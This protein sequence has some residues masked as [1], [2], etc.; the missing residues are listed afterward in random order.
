MAFVRSLGPQANSPN[1]VISPDTV[2]LALPNIFF[3]NE[4]LLCVTVAAG[5][6]AVCATPAG[7]G[8]IASGGTN[9]KIYVFGRISDGT[10][11]FVGPQLAW[12][13]LTTGTAGTPWM[14]T[15]YSVA[16][17]QQ[18]LTSI[19]DGVAA[20]SDQ[21][22]SS[23]IQAGGGALTTAVANSVVV[24]VAARPDDDIIG[25]MTPPVAGTDGVPVWN[26]FDSESTVSGAD[27]GYEVYWGTK[28][29]AG[30]VSAKTISLTGLGATARASS[31]LQFALKAG[32]PIY[33]PYMSIL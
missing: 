21:A 9:M 10:E 7:Y 30:A 18:S 1:A 17:I 24:I 26:R 29:T 13:G 2:A 27:A 32:P 14:G 4:L 23:T 22:L 5:S 12:S 20:A 8:L 25:F 28:P 3:Q 15:C 6:T 11:I 16:G 33:S 31:A 19:L